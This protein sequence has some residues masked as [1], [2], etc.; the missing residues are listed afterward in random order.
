MHIMKLRKN[1]FKVIPGWNRRVKAKHSAARE[2]Y[3]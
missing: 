1:K 3:Y 2:K